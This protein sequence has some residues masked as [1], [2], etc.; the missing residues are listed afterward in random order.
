[1]IATSYPVKALCLAMATATLVGA[2]QLGRTPET[3]LARQGSG[4][5]APARLGS[6]FEDMSIGTLTAITPQTLSPV[7]PTAAPQPR[8]A[9]S[10]ATAPV[11]PTASAQLSVPT[12]VV[13]LAAPVLQPLTGSENAAASPQSSSRPKLRDPLR[14]AKAA[15]KPVPKPEP[16]SRTAPQGNAARDNA[17]GSATGSQSANAPTQGAQTQQSNQ[18]GTATASTYPGEVMRR[19]SRVSKPRV[20]SRGTAVVAFSISGNGGLAE[21]S[22]ARSSGSAKL[23]QVALSVIRKAAPFPAPP[24]GAQRS[25]SINIKGR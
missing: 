8:E 2:A 17:K 1:M 23:D 11:L 12:A 25:F 9:V 5:A 14:A 15:P 3:V 21:L 22:I 18:S 20:N 16:Q 7:A 10:T 24:S 6:S 13:P 4:E 19:I